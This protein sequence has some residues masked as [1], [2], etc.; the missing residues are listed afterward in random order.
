MEN[1][2]SVPQKSILWGIFLLDD[3][4]VGFSLCLLFQVKDSLHD[5][6]S[7]K[8]SVLSVPLSLNLLTFGW[9]V[10]T[11]PFENTITS[12]SLQPGVYCKVFALRF[13]SLLLVFSHTLIQFA[14]RLLF[15]FFWLR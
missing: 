14:N 12:L 3:Q 10:R 1:V 6:M 13:L 5:N 11:F 4:Q 2:S 7:G 8:Q 9:G 15:L